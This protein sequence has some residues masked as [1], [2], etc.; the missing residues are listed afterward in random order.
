MRRHCILV[1]GM[2]RGGT[3][4]LAGTLHHAGI[5]F[6]SNFIATLPENP[7]GFYEN[8][9]INHLDYN[10]LARYDYRW[11]SIFRAK[12][13]NTE[14]REKLTQIMRREF[15]SLSLF[16]IKE[17]R[18]VHFLEAYEEVLLRED[19]QPI[20]LRVSR[21]AFSVAKSIQKRDRIPIWYGLALAKFYERKI[22]TFL[23][24]RKS[25]QIDYESLLKDPDIATR[26]LK[27]FLDGHHS[28]EVEL[29][30]KRGVA[31][32]ET[33]LNHSRQTPPFWEKLGLLSL[34]NLFLGI[35]T[36]SPRMGKFSHKFLERF[37][38]V[39]VGS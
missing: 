28:L 17:P 21:N 13:A 27:K 30:L 12:L 39:K 29:N 38:T 2:H 18:M 22:N 6:G 31:F 9:A 10:T 35:S 23:H 16:G 37:Y 14:F 20:Y 36:L 33:K 1:L 34:A 15:A 11:Y 8:Q 7:K 25:W 24:S 4:S 32:L 3:S 19:I 5:S 26:S